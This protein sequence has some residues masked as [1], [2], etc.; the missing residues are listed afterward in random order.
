MSTYQDF[1]RAV[2]KLILECFNVSN[3]GTLER[4]HP[5]NA[6]EAHTIVDNAETSV[7]SHDWQDMNPT[8]RH[9]HL[10]ALHA[11]ANAVIAHRRG[12]VSPATICAWL[13][14]VVSHEDFNEALSS[15]GRVLEHVPAFN[16]QQIDQGI[17]PSY[18]TVGSNEPAPSFHSRDPP[19]YHTNSGGRRSSHAQSS[20]Q[21]HG[22]RHSN[23]QNS[24]EPRRSRSLRRQHEE[25]QASESEGEEPIHSRSPSRVPSPSPSHV[26]SRSPR[27]RSRSRPRTSDS[28]N[29]GRRGAV[30]L[31]RHEH[32][33]R[34]SSS[35]EE[36]HRRRRRAVDL[37]RPEGGYMHE[38]GLRQQLHYKKRFV[39][40]EFF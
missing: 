31:E 16:R 5:N 40:G 23:D 18:H 24:D 28:S 27:A 3:M 35:S 32:P 9:R 1:K 14:M 38:L 29:G 12:G 25:E 2:I 20:N 17:M 37:P 33:A 11:L 19:S 15:G 39:K 30:E 7:N 22:D 8:E 26:R 34:N 4:E 10:S 36:Q 21:S 13:V 6:H